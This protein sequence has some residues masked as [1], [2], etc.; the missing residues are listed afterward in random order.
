MLK[1]AHKNLEVWQRSIYLIKIVYELTKLLPF[2]EQYNLISQMRRAAV[3]VASNIAEGFSRISKQEKITIRS[4][5]NRLDL[6][7]A[8]M[9]RLL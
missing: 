3:S 9:S 5:R 2:D 6:N 7:L 4:I 1:L 8:I